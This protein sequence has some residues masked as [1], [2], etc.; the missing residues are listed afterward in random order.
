[1]KTLKKSEAPL[2]QWKLEFRRMKNTLLAGLLALTTG[3][4]AENV[5]PAGTILPLQLNTSLNSKK[6]KPGQVVTARLMQDVP[7][8][9]GAKIHAG[10]KVV[11]HIIDVVDGRNGT[12]AKLSLQLDTLEFSKRRIPM[13][14]NLRALASMMEVED[15]Q[16]PKTGPDHGTPENWWTT[17]Q[18]GG[19][20]VYRGGGPV[21][22][23]LRVVGTPTANGV[24]VRIASKPGTKCRS[25]L[26]GNH[27]PQALWL[28]SADAGGTYGFADLTIAHAG[29]SRPVGQIT[30]ASEKRNFDVRSGSGLLLRVK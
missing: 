17:V 9:S 4:F 16:I 8:P 15:A 11:G 5:I 19:D 26:G 1:M 7:L 21:A 22:N 23:G 24:L 6:S 28:F 3:L 18:I 20:V 14:T 30:L 2:Y 13:T 25:D 27:L 10:A 12:G 29:R